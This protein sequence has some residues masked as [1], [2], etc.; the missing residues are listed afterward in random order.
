MSNA[1]NLE[2]SFSELTI[3][4]V[5]LFEVLG[6]SKFSQDDSEKE[7]EEAHAEEKAPECITC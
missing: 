1:G 5:P 3:F 2:F 4:S 7:T 6:H